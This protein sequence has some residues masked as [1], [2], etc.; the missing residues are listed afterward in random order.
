M[1]LPLCFS[2]PHL[3][4]SSYFLIGFFPLNYPS[5]CRPTQRFLPLVL[6]FLESLSLKITLI[7]R[8]QFLPSRQTHPAV[9]ASFHLCVAFSRATFQAVVVK[10]LLCSRSTPL[11]SQMYGIPFFLLVFMRPARVIVDSRHLKLL[12]TSDCCHKAVFV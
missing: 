2:I 1:E 6:A 3:F 7:C 8:S 9:A 11:G 5:P 12:E 10:R 4:K